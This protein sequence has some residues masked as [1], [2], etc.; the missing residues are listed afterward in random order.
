[1]MQ[2][3]PRLAQ[4]L[5]GSNQINESASLTDKTLAWDSSVAPSTLSYELDRNFTD[6]S[7]EDII[8][9][10]A[11]SPITETDMAFDNLTVNNISYVMEP[12]SESGLNSSDLIEVQFYQH[13]KVPASCYLPWV[14]IQASYMDYLTAAPAPWRVSVFNAT[15]DILKNPFPDT[16]ISGLYNDTVN[17]AQEYYPTSNP[18][19]YLPHWENVSLP[20]VLLNANNTYYYDGYYH[21]FVA[22]LMPNG[23]SD[24]HYWFYS[25]DSE[26]LGIDSGLAYGAAT[27]DPPGPTGRVTLL[28]REIPAIDFTLITELVPITNTPKPEDI[29]LKV[30]GELVINTGNGSGI[31]FTD[32]VLYPIDNQVRYD[33]TSDWSDFAQGTMDYDLSVEYTIRDEISPEITTIFQE[34]NDTIQW[35]LSYLVSFDQPMGSERA[36]L[37]VDLPVSWQNIKIIN[38][39]AGNSSEWSDTTQ[40]A[41]PTGKY[42]R[43]VAS[44]LTSGTWMVTCES[45]LLSANINLDLFSGA[46]N[47]S[48]D[49]NSTVTI[50]SGPNGENYTL[51]T[52]YEGGI[53]NF[54]SLIGE[55][56][57]SLND[58]LIWL[59]NK[60]IRF[61]N[62]TALDL[63]T[64]IE[65][66][67]NG[68]LFIDAN[69]SNSFDIFFDV[70]EGF[71]EDNL[72]ELSLT[73][74]HQSSNESWWVANVTNEDPAALMPEN[75]IYWNYNLTALEDVR[76]KLVN[77]DFDV[78][79]IN[80]TY[81]VS[82]NRYADLYFNLSAVVL[83]NDTSIGPDRITRLIIHMISN[84]S[85][86]DNNQALFI[87]NQSS[88]FF[89]QLN[90]TTYLD[91]FFNDSYLYWDSQLE[92]NITNITNLINPINNTVEF[93]V[94]TFNTTYV[95]TGLPGHLYHFDMGILNWTYSNPLED[96]TLKIYNWTSGDYCAQEFTFSPGTGK[97]QTIL[98]FNSST[99]NLQ[100]IYDE[101][102]NSIR[103]LIDTNC[104]VPILNKISWDLDRIL[105]KIT[106]TNY[107]RCNWTERIFS[108]S[109]VE[110]YSGSLTTLFESP[111]NNFSSSIPVQDYI[112]APGQYFYEILWHNGSDVVVNSTSFNISAFETNITF[113]QDVYYDNTSSSWR[114]VK[115]SR[116]YVNDTTK[117]FVV[118]VRDQ[119]FGNPV[120]GGMIITNWTGPAP[121][122][123]D[124]YALNDNSTI[125]AGQYEIILDTTGLDETSSNPIEVELNF[126]KS[127]YVS[128]V[129]SLD[130]DILP[131]PVNIIPAQF[132]LQYYE[133]QDFSMSLSVLESFHNVPLENV[134]VNWSIDED[135]SINGTLNH[136][137]F[138]VYQGQT[139]LAQDSLT[140]GNYIL[141]YFVSGVNVETTNDSVPLEILPTYDIDIIKHGGFNDNN[142]MSGNSLS[143]E[144]QLRYSANTSAI[145]DKMLKMTITAT[146]RSGGEETRE[147][148][149]TTDDG[150]I[151]LF[152]FQ[153]LDAWSSFSY[154]VS[155]SDDS[156]E[157]KPTPDYQSDEIQVQNVIEYV[158][159]LVMDNWMIITAV[160]GILIIA[161]VAKNQ[162][163]R[164]KK[165][166]WKQDA[167]VIRDVVKIQHMLV[168]MKASGSCVV[169]RAY[170]QSQFDGDLISGFLTA[171]ATF[172]KEVGQK[173]AK[174]T[175]DAILFDYQEFK[176]LIQ[177]GVN[178]RTALILDGVPTDNLK[179]KLKLFSDLFEQR[180]DLSSW[181][182]NLDMFSDV[183]GLIEQAFEITLIYPLVVKP[184]TVKKD[185]KSGLGKALFEVGEAVQAEKHAFYLSTLLNFAQAGRKESQDQVLS[186]IYQL[187]KN[188]FLTFY[189]P[190]T[191]GKV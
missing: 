155:F 75:P 184:G 4:L 69:L 101:N 14:S 174:I 54:S 173:A 37:A 150:G 65:M 31:Y 142:I 134:I 53:L 48:D 126:S 29:G 61:K 136:V 2:G 32:G 28:I 102:T 68:T 99:I 91:A 131:L 111:N 20:H 162:S 116:P 42:N 133:N 149:A 50:P 82:E 40:M 122:V 98:S 125:Y 124:L 176:I 11:T 156:P 152:S 178:S 9:I 6:V 114:L 23:N 163:D 183:D 27:Y 117:S 109:L 79:P 132:Q 145:P 47:V 167:N 89:V 90:T 146:L 55:A 33:I 81:N 128:S 144:F 5:G 151:V 106:F 179:E 83:E 96:F 84:F 112:Q 80:F 8:A 39:T 164:K 185:I 1:M 137:L 177:D 140:A 44:N 113:F 94:R 35:N 26:G 12:Y 46:I 63:L 103:I 107:M 170:S 100:D 127:N 190:Q 49:L 86:Y 21:F 129:I 58:T 154:S 189:N 158:G 108:T 187:K 119:V 93:F 43:F 165:R 97:T 172:G 60:S 157:F 188:G 45:S 24:L 85:K 104:T 120:T 121:V 138:G 17:P 143:V 95:N 141:R 148:E 7:D 19:F 59:D 110:K 147:I 130:V 118:L 73:L 30:N 18:A 135:P 77:Y 92:N 66:V 74:D 15:S 76:R 13:L 180:Y 191:A 161:V 10:P 123:N 71:L 41:L 181:R 51:R 72:H 57:S 160:G 153:A 22:V 166:A 52:D 38:T 34:G 169:N 182:G 78:V 168:I 105:G 3:N 159:Q 175:G 70:E 16:E 36:S 186:E 64:I 88:G 25:R 67:T 115:S 139:N 87:K 171:I 56:N 62:E